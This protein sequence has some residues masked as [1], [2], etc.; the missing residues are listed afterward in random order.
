MQLQITEIQKKIKIIRYCVF[1]LHSDLAKG[2]AS[3]PLAPLLVV[4]LSVI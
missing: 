2:G 3:A 4:P 1:F